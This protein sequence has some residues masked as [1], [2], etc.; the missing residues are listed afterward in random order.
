MNYVGVICKSAQEVIKAY[1]ILVN[2]GFNTDYCPTVEEA[3]YHA[4]P[5]MIEEDGPVAVGVDCYRDILV[6]YDF[7]E[8]GDCIA[9]FDNVVELANEHF[10]L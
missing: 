3:L 2:S 1:D 6:V 5:P 7:G 9:T 4:L 8:D 10:P